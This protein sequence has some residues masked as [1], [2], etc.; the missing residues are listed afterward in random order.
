M[1]WLSLLYPLGSAMGFQPVP[2]QEGTAQN[3][4][5]KAL[6]LLKVVENKVTMDEPR[7][8]AQAT[9]AKQS[10]ETLI[11]ALEDTQKLAVANYEAELARVEQEVEETDFD[12]Y[13]KK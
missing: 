9:Q 4:A 5:R 12:K 3:L 11:S 8:K 10:V 2:G 13:R 6:A 1:P 7:L